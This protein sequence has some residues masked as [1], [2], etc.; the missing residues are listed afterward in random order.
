VL[1]IPKALLKKIG[2]LTQLDMYTRFETVS[3]KMC[4]IWEVLI[5]TE[6]EQNSNARRQPTHNWM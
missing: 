4:G 1:K 5:N 2:E 6:V 3:S